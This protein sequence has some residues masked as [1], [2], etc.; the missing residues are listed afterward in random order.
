MNKMTTARLLAALWITVLTI[1]SC[2]KDAK[3]NQNSSSV[4]PDNKWANAEINAFIFKAISEKKQVFDW[5]DASDEML[6]SALNNSDNLLAVGFK[7]AE[8]NNEDAAKQN[9]TNSP[10][11]KAAK[12]AVVQLIL[13]NEKRANPTLDFSKFEMGSDFDELNAFYIRVTSFETVV[14][15]RQSQL[16]RYI[17]PSGNGDNGYKP[18]AGFTAPNFYTEITPGAKRPWSYSYSKIPAAWS[19]ARGLGVGVMVIDAGVSNDQ[20]MLQQSNF[21]SGESS[22]N[23]TIELISTYPAELNFW[24]TSVIRYEQSP[25]SDCGHGTA[26]AGIVASPRNNSGASVGVAYNCNLVSCRA[27]DDV[28]IEDSK[29]ELGVAKAITTAK[30]RTDIRIVSMS[31]GSLIARNVIG[32]AIIAFHNAGKLAF[33]AAGSSSIYTAPIASFFQIVVY[34]ASMSQ[35]NA[36]TGVAVT[37]VTDEYKRCRICHTGSKVDFTAVMENDK[38]NGVTTDFTNVLTLPVK[39]LHPTQVGGSSA[40]TATVAGIAAL[41]WGRDL[42]QTRQQVLNRLKNNS[43]FSAS[44][45]SSDFGHGVINADAA[46]NF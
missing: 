14:K 11:W 35:A 28:Q 19:R 9:A 44:N 41:V 26:M 17:Y 6:W 24:G 15:L 29:E 18:I 2:Q 12:N 16:V 38:N 13:E 45:L 20:V 31:V 22:Y 33:C 39:E 3:T 37:D 34:P 23:R 8:A 30:N 40:A 32:D 4:L 27:T 1:V 21:A 7:P 10:N 25:Y 36:V 42:N 46:T 5:S 43:Q